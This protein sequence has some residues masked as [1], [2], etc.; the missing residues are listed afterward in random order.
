MSKNLVIVES[1][2]K[3]GTIEK[4][5]GKDFMVRASYGHVRDLPKS[6]LG[7][8]VEH[9]FEPQYI[10]P[11]KAKKTVS[12]LKE[13]LKKVKTLYLATDL[14]REGEA[15]AW[16][17]S[18][19]L[20][21]NA[22]K[23]KVKS[24]KLKVKES[25]SDD[26]KVHRIVFNQITDS[27]VK[28]AV[29]NPRELDINLVNAQQARRV[30]DR[31]VGYKLS[32]FL[33]RKVK[34][35]LS[36][37]RVQSVAV[38]LV[39]EREREIQA[40]N[41][42]EYWEL[43]AELIKQ[44][45]KKAKKQEEKFQA[46]LIKKDG[47][48]LKVVNKEQADQILNELEKADYVVGEVRRKEKNRYPSPPFT[49]ST[50]Q[51]EAA[52]KLGFSAKK[53]M[54]VAQR[55]YEGMNLGS[56][57]H[58]GL[59]TYMRTDSLNLASEAL[60]AIRQQINDKFGKEYLPDNANFYK[61][62]SKGA[63]EAHEA[64]RPSHPE[65]SPD[66]VEAYLDKDQ[67]RLY[68]LIWKRAVASQMVPAVMDTTSVDINAKN[69]MFRAT[70]SVVKFPGFIKVYIEDI[71]EGDKI[72]EEDKEGFLPPLNEKD[73]LDLVNL[74]PQ[75]KFTQPPP[76]FTEA[77]L[78]KE[79]EK[80]EIGRPSTYAP[81][82]ATIQDRGYVTLIE[83]KFHPQEI[84]LIVNDVLVEHFPQ[85]VDIGFTAKVEE[86]FDDIAEGK[87]DWHKMIKDFYG[88]FEK[89]LEEKDK[90]I[91]KEDIMGEEKITDIMC[92]KCGKPLK[93]KFGR[94]GKFL[95]CT[96]FPDC[97]HTQPLEETK[98]EAEAVKES[99]GGKCEKC[100]SEMVIKQGRFG[101]FLACSAYPKCKNV[102]SMN[103][104]K[105]DMKCPDCGK[106]DVVVKFTKRRK[107][108]WGCSAYPD[109]KWAS[110]E[111]PTKGQENIKTKNQENKEEE[112]K[113]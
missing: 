38:R 94:F 81:T 102:K 48:E 90:D 26:I 72:D 109:C 1:P 43:I 24:S 23:L 11:T 45:S 79:L 41:P 8:D 66:D 77:S 4:I 36:A 31:L 54:M 78:V 67:I 46:K 87:E 104:Q 62:K 110:W 111:D 53:T 42:E 57:G 92:P 14:D 89:N 97:K 35:G 34:K 75:Q 55:L 29:A 52:R 33:W 68:T 9:D 64:I 88:P 108:F 99:N 40:F 103:E 20:G 96:G 106:G 82:L 50:L 49:T 13:D 39:V 19:A 6:K 113:D 71:D 86:E 107:K 73:N 63:Q 85:I 21:L 112:K 60:T 101:K 98:E 37:G 76:R 27:A 69:Y 25:P 70:G 32:P 2:A 3:A 44:E 56:H 16:H 105:L 28:D 95:A 22:K 10:I 93:E 100:G 80:N 47:K 91:S 58:L 65:L 59:I 15:I 17:L 12:A 61:N 74:D 5:L 84:G 30:L 83:K 7:V 18:I 51:Q